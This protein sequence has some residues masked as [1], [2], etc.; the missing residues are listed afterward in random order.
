MK[1]LVLTTD[2]TQDN[3]NYI[4]EFN[5]KIS[6]AAIFPIKN[7]FNENE[8]NLIKESVE[9]SS[10]QTA[11][12]PLH[13]QLAAGLIKNEKLNNDAAKEIVKNSFLEMPFGREIQ[14]IDFKQNDLEALQALDWTKFFFD[15]HLDENGTTY[16]IKGNEVSEKAKTN[17]LKGF[18]FLNNEWPEY[19]ELGRRLCSYIVLVSSSRFQSGVTLN[20]FGA[21]F[22]NIMNKLQYPE[23]LE[24]YVHEVAHLHLLAHE[25]TTQF[26]LNEE[27]KVESPLRQDMRPLRGSFHSCYALVRMSEVLQRY[28]KR[29][30]E[31]EF[32]LEM[33]KNNVVRL[34]K[35]LLIVNEKAKLS[36]EGK[37]LFNSMQNKMSEFKI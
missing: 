20:T 31:D 23:V 27:E 1:K 32:A 25:Q 6:K 37:E 26:V 36:E 13:M 28:T 22:T 18:D 11:L 30:P 35:G 2:I 8:L 21:I 14:F 4:A 7:H 9:R 15:T 3:L 19:A 12:Q 5:K 29:N 33:F 17:L 10:A 24:I 16:L 34:K